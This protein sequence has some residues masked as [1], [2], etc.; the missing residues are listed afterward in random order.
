MNRLSSDSCCKK[1][2]EGSRGSMGHSSTCARKESGE[3]VGCPAGDQGLGSS[4]ALRG[5]PSKAPHQGT[6]SSGGQKGHVTPSHRP[7]SSHW[8]A[9]LPPAWQRS[10]RLGKKQTPPDGQYRSPH[11]FLEPLAF[12]LGRCVLL[13]FGFLLHLC[14]MLM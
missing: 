7:I 1:K 10:V 13:W 4:Q 6:G 11:R 2:G 5:Q 9:P 8:W 14:L 12:P 3:G